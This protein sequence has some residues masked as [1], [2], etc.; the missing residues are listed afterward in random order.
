MESNTDI[1]LLNGFIWAS[2]YEYDQTLNKY[3]LHDEKILNDL[4]RFVIH[5]L[6]RGDFAPGK[7]SASWL[8]GKHRVS[9]DKLLELS[10]LLMLN[11][12]EALN[13]HRWEEYI[14]PL[15]EHWGI[16]IGFTITDSGSK[17]FDRIQSLDIDKIPDGILRYIVGKIE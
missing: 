8:I 14:L 4:D 12:S 7:I 5:K 13:K 17:K 11:T 6:K 1:D 3:D 10:V 15:K 2:K 16:P 9:L